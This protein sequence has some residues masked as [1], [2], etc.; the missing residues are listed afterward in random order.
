MSIIPV[1]REKFDEKQFCHR[2]LSC[3]TIL[4]ENIE[5]YL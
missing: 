2:Y 4:E 5:I 3:Q 1:L